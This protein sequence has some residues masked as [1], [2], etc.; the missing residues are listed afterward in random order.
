[1]DLL[2]LLEFVLMELKLVLQC[3]LL[4]DLPT[5]G[6]TLYRP[7]RQKSLQSDQGS[8][9][10]ATMKT[11]RRDIERSDTKKKRKTKKIKKIRKARRRRKIR[12][13][14]MNRDIVET[15]TDGATEEMSTEMT[16]ETIAEMIEEIADETKGEM[17]VEMI[18]ETIGGS[19]V[20]RSPLT[21]D[22]MT[23]RST[24][25]SSY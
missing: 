18:G 7:V 11:K 13:T 8:A 9:M 24:Q 4:C 15:T 21:I 5:K 12:K 2:L 1:L 17:I 23:K 20:P 16:G 22:V 6:V 10:T 25:R 3:H 19:K 14:N